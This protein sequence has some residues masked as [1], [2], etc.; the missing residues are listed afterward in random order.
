MD[1]LARLLRVHVAPRT[2]AEISRATKAFKSIRNKKCPFSDEDLAR[3]VVDVD[4]SAPTV[5]VNVV[6]EISADSDG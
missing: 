1:R 3:S 2:K 6:D 5:V 4:E